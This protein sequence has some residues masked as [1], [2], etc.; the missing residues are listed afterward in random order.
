MYKINNWM[1]A[2]NPTNLSEFDEEFTPGK[3]QVG[4]W[5]DDDGWSDRYAC[6]AGCC[7]TEVRE[8][9]LWQKILALFTTFH[10]IVVGDGIDP[11]R[12]HQEFLK[13]DE[14][15]RRISPDIPGALSA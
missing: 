14:Y 10:S 15:R 9:P 2:W 1:V 5:P 4:P 8:A 6:T 13:I 7:Y 3:I 12:A 11:M